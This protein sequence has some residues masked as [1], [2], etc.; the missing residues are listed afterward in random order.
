MVKS[1][2]PAITIAA[3]ALLTQSCDADASPAYANVGLE[4]AQLYSDPSGTT[5]ADGQLLYG[6]IVEFDSN[7]N[8]K[9]VKVRNI[10]TG[11]EGYVDTLSICAA[12]YPLE[13]PEVMT[14]E[15]S[16][17]RLLNIETADNGETTAGWVFW[18]EGNEVKALNS[19][20]M[21]YDTGRMFTQENYYTGETHPG[22]ILLTKQIEY[23]S[24]QGEE[25]ETPI[26]VYEDIAGRAGIF[27][28]GQCF[29]PGGRL[30]GFDTD[31]WE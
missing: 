4:G 17:C 19:V 21:V 3:M 27:V 9:F 6:E 26:V 28:N 11:T 20:T 18:K 30:C 24:E 23:G 7:N 16:E 31:D 22:Y 5:K 25:L 10:A 29:T 15:Q 14:E 8:G 13:A 2:I 1:L 12:Q